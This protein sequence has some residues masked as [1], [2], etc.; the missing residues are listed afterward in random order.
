MLAELDKSHGLMPFKETGCWLNGSPRRFSTAVSWY[1]TLLVA[2]SPVIIVAVAGVTVARMAIAPIAIAAAAAAMVPAT[3][4][5]ALTAIVVTVLPTPVPGLGIRGAKDQRE[6]RDEHCK[7][8]SFSRHYKTP[9]ESDQHEA[10]AATMTN[11]T[12][13][14]AN[15]GKEFTTSASSIAHIASNKKSRREETL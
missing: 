14:A 5:A 10:A 4:I 7:E 13:D 6:R 1:P 2:V 9:F 11:K 12:A 3:V 15:P 8:Q